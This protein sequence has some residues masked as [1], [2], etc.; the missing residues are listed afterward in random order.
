MLIPCD[1]PGCANRRV[2]Y[3]KDTP[4]GVQMIEVPDVRGIP[5]HPGPYFC[6]IECHVYYLHARNLP[7][8]PELIYKR[9]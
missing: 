1:G 6:S 9:E 2:H 8:N 7:V 4:R 3:E 5:E